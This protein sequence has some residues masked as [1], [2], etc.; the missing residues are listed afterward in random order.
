MAGITASKW[1]GAAK[2]M[3]TP[4]DTERL[5]QLV[6]WLGT[7]IAINT[8]DMFSEVE[9]ASLKNMEEV[10]GKIVALASTD[11][12]GSG[13]VMHQYVESGSGRLYAQGVNLQTA[14]RLVKQAAL[15]GLWEYD[16]RW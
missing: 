9:M 13:F 8:L 1:T 4:V 7:H 5:S 16:I 3:P 14:P 12:A 2:M 15:H 10:A 6:K 11:V